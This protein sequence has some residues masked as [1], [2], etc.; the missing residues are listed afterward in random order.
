MNTFSKTE[1]IFSYYLDE[2]KKV[3]KTVYLKKRFQM[4][5]KFTDFVNNN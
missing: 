5:L 2:L 3:K 1:N 4:R